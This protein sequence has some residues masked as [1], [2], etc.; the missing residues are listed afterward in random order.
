MFWLV[1]GSR[2]S[3]QRVSRHDMEPVAVSHGSD[4]ELLLA[5]AEPFEEALQLFTTRQDYRSAMNVH[6]LPELGDKEVARLRASDLDQ[7]YARLAERGLGAARFS[8]NSVS[9]SSPD[10]GVAPRALPRAAFGA[11]HGQVAHPFRPVDVGPIEYHVA[12]DEHASGSS[13]HGLDRF[14]RLDR[15]R[16]QHLLR[17]KHRPAI[18]SHAQQRRLVWSVV[19]RWAAA[20]LHGLRRRQLQRLLDGD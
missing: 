9:S 4:D 13:G 17:A 7:L 12:T 10:C 18:A 16:H 20:L 3:S 11:P 5:G 19:T 14:V 1:R 2:V 15:S 6:L 8:M